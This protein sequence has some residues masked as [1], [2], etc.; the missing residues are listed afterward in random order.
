M[1]RGY[2]GGFG[3][4]GAES[5]LLSAASAL[6]PALV[7]AQDFD[8]PLD[9]TAIAGA[10]GLLQARWDASVSAHLCIWRS[11]AEALSKCETRLEKFMQATA[12]GILFP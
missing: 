4:E 3:Q 12:E 1:R 6:L 5:A 7:Q 2:P 8:L 10:A 9:L 11:Q